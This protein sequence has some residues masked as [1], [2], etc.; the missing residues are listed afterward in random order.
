ML[1]LGEGV[2]MREGERGREGEIER[3]RGPGK[4]TQMRRMDEWIQYSLSFVLHVSR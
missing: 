2:L 1:V 3:K 4:I